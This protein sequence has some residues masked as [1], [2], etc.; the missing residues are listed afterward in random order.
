MVHVYPASPFIEW[1]DSPRQTRSPD[2]RRPT[3]V[4]DVRQEVLRRQASAGNS[5][6]TMVRD[7]RQSTDDGR[8]LSPAH[9]CDTPWSSRSRWS[10]AAQSPT[11]DGFVERTGPFP[12]RQ[13]GSAPWVAIAEASVAATR[14]DGSL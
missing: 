11:P 3:E 12:H 7:R 1:L 13:T 10:R 8:W 2:L 9:P 6:D 14:P 4:P 5:G